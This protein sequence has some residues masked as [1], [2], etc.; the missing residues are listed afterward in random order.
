[1]KDIFIYGISIKLLVLCYTVQA[2][3]EASKAQLYDTLS[4]IEQ[5]WKNL[6]SEPSRSITDTEQPSLA[7]DAEGENT[8]IPVG[9]LLFFSAYLRQHYLG[10]LIAIKSETGAWIDLNNLVEHLNFAITVN[11]NNLTA[12]GWYISQANRFE[13]N[14]NNKT[15]LLNGDTYSISEEDY[16]ID[17]GDIF[18]SSARLNEWFLLN[19]QLSFSS[20]ELVMSPEAKLPLE[21]KMQ[22]EGRV[23]ATNVNNREPTLPWK[24]SPYKAASAPVADLQLSY[25]ATNSNQSLN[26]SILGSQDL[27]YLKSEYYIAGRDDDLISNS[28]LSF[29]REDPNENLLG[30]LNASNIEFGDILAT[31]I[32]KRFDGNYARGFKFNNKPLYKEVNNNQINLTGAIQAGWDVELYRNKILIAQQLSSQ[33]GRYLF[34]NIDLLF[35]TNIFELIFY[36]PQGQVERKVEEYLIDGNSLE[37]GEGFYD[38]S[39]TQTGKSL[40]NTS[41]YRDQ[42]GWL[43]SGRFERGIT[44]NLSVYSGMSALNSETGDN[45]KKYALGSNFSLFNKILINL[46]YEESTKHEKEF[47]IAARSEF[48]GQSVRFS[49]RQASQLLANNE[50]NA[51]SDFDIYELFFSGNVMRNNYGQLSYQNT[52]SHITRGSQDSLLR[53]GN[54]LNYYMNGYSFNNSL[55]WT[56]NDTFFG[57]SRL[58]KRFGRL[59]TRIG[60][61]YSI[62]PE[63]EITSYETEFSRSL[64]SDLQAELKLTYQLENH[65]KFAELGLNWQADLFSL[66][67]NFNY[68]SENNWRVGLFGRFS[69]GFDRKNNYFLNKRSLVQ[70]GSLMVHVYLDENNNSVFDKGEKSL[71]GVKV[72]GVQNFRRAITDEN[73]IALLSAMPA[74]LTTDI[75]IDA[76]SISDPF[77]IAATDGFSITPRAGFVEYMEIPFN[78]S[79]EIEG[80]VYLQQD[81]KPS[82]V[83]P[84]AKVELRDQQG[85]LVAQTQAAYDG[86]YL[87]TDL[88]PGEYKAVIDDEFKDRKSLKATQQVTVNLPAQGEVVMGVDFELKEKTQT[89]AYIANAGRF[90][91]LPIM[92]AYY[93]LIKSHLSPQLTSNA[94]YIKDKEQQRYILAIAYADSAQGKL[95][96]VCSELTT[97]GLTCTVQAQLISH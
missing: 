53:I 96:Q 46:D 54:N 91:S 4:N 81:G 7:K 8:G 57:R 14:L 76:D 38:F 68:D 78:N 79:S 83:Q 59:S 39:L 82:E 92:K 1:M 62:E 56:D 43:L 25:S 23:L 42:P 66:N 51:T 87:F 31:Q 19:L 58:Q 18:I 24:A 84:F 33:D 60:V 12:Q 32:G 11:K 69:L 75:V 61:N 5:K 90:T 47:E 37:Q 93:Q 88:R 48:A 72:K 9:E 74:N 89:P 27:A 2:S 97:K 44:D 36:G 50:Y 17:S 28:R 52:A 22:R 45:E 40:L 71:E 10:E 41:D 49:M 29:S 20:L 65:V 55:Q 80:T 13:L 3:P 77:L 67:S 35:G 94:F 6:P 70:D 73:G 34:E 21:E 26:Y 85:K 64:T 95:E 86:Y 30:P 63:S 15:I 16:Y